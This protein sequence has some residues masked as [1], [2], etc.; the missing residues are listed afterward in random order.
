M[1]VHVTGREMIS[2]RGKFIDMEAI[3]LLMKEESS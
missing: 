3:S 2:Q 1:S